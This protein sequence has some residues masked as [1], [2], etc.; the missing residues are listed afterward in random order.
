M[1]LVIVESPAKGKTIEKYLGKDYRVLASFGHVRDLPKSRLGIDVDHDF[2][3]DYRILPKAKKTIQT[4]AAASRQADTV[5]LATD[6]D[7]EGEAIAWHLAEALGLGS[8]KRKAKSQKLPELKRIT[9]HEITKEAIQGAIHHPRALNE[10]LINAQQARRLLDRLVGYK[11]SPFLWKKVL[12]GL[13]AG[14]VQ[15]VAVRLIVDREREIEAFKADEYWTL[16]AYLAKAKTVFPARLVAIGEDTL[17]KLS[18][19]SKEALAVHLSRLEHARYEVTSLEVREQ[20]KRPSAPFTTST[21][22]QTAAHRLDFSAKKTMKLAQDLYEDGQI[23]YMRTDSTNLASVAIAAIRSYLEEQL[24]STYLPAA[25]QVYRKLAKGAQEA[26]EAIR[27]TAPGKA[28]AAVKT[29]SPDH[30]R[31]Y[32]LIWRRTLASQMPPAR[33]G[34]TKVII[35]AKKD[36]SAYTFQ[37]NGSQVLFDGFTRI[38]LT[39]LEE[40]TLPQLASGDALELDKLDPQQH[41]TEPPARFNEASLVKALEKHGIGR[42]STYAPTIGTIQ[43][44]GYVRVENRVFFPEEIGLV[45]TDLL[46][47]HFPNIIDIAFTARLEDELDEI[48]EGKRGWVATLKA[49]YEPFDKQLLEKTESV[50][51][52]NLVNEETDEVCEK[53]GKPMQVKLGRFGKFL[54]CTG[55]PDCRNTKPFLIPSGIK[56]QVCGEGDLVERQTRRRKKFWSCSQY[57]DCKAATWDLKKPATLPDP[58]KVSRWKRKR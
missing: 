18:L 4:L 23:T 40:K 57:P 54:A 31:L 47:E 42:P 58:N 26:H 30:A 10:D 13:S 41:F 6:L 37:A 38:W 8:Q 53:C 34:M 45:V 35:D 11:L 50:A 43:D 21:L 5:Y 32:D 14:R 3:P 44:R 19:G 20:Q 52:Q 2:A 48:A 56:C 36:D 25:P 27:P 15:S 22:Q 55:F 29:E 33:I 24:G 17:D 28:V 49:F 7:R 9:F 12:K 16:D 51:K 39:Q 46:K 1:N